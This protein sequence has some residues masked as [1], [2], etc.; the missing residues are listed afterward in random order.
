[1]M[2]IHDYRRATFF[3]SPVEQKTLKMTYKE[4]CDQLMGLKQQKS[5]E[6]NKRDRMH[7]AQ[8]ES[9]F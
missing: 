6:E 9:L 2:Q 8:C 3:G 7:T 1:M 5:K 4:E